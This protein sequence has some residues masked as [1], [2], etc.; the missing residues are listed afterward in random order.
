MV[1]NSMAS[2]SDLSTLYPLIWLWWS[3]PPTFIT[4][5]SFKNVCN[6][7]AGCGRLKCPDMI[8]YN[9]LL[10]G[11]ISSSNHW[12][13]YQGLDF[14]WCLQQ[15]ATSKSLKWLTLREDTSLI[16]TTKHLCKP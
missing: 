6:Y 4:F 10:H 13:G 2:L 9:A 3:S 5:L 7:G 12:S 1:L 14:T 16:Y 15:R 11:E 8:P